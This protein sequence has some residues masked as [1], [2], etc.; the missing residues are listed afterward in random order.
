MTVGLMIECV[1]NWNIVSPDNY[2]GGTLPIPILREHIV[3]LAH[4]KNKVLYSA[5]VL[6]ICTP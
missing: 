3:K 5:K 4:K 2:S 6:E 1:L